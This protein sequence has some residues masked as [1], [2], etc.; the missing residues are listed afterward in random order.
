MIRLTLTY[1]QSSD[2]RQPGQVLLNFF[3]PGFRQVPW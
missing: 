1:P 3:A 2:D